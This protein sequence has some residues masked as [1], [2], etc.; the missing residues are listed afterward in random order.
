MTLHALDTSPRGTAV[1]VPPSGGSPSGRRSHRPRADCTA[2]SA[3]GLTF[4][5]RLSEETAKEAVATDAPGHAAVL[6]RLRHH[7]GP[8][9]SLRLPLTRAAAGGGRLRAT[10]PSTVRLREGRWDAYLALADEEPQRL[11]PGVHDLRSIVDGVPFDAHAGLAVRIPYTTKHGHLTVRAWLRRPHAEAGA[12]RVEDSAIVLE[13]R[14]Y[15]AQLS[16]TACL[17]AHP[18]DSAALPV[19]APVRVECE[20]R[21]R[22]TTAPEYGADGRRPE[23]G[24][25]AE[26]PFSALLPGHRVWDLW[27]RP[28][29]E[30]EPVRLARILDDV[31]DKKRIFSYPSRRVAT[32]GVAVHLVRP[33]YT[34]NNNLSVRV[35]YEGPVQEDA[36]EPA[37]A[38]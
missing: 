17:E 25:A 4:D 34:V 15:G 6:L 31:P 30:E 13:G 22:R 35:S 21:S 19:R 16:A 7:H 9:A 24:F 14:L 2:D 36:A 32:P 8:D 18:R 37:S 3:G 5:V 27:L 28:S 23:R 33:Y 10:L 38:A 26:L 1:A 29:A 11:L 20:E 12:L